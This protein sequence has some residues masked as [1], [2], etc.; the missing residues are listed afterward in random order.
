MNMSAQ[1]LRVTLPGSDRIPTLLLVDDEP[2]ILSAL[3]RLT[4]HEPWRIVT[5]NS[6]QEALDL[7]VTETPALIVSD[8]RMPGMSGADLLAQA[9]ECRPDALRL[10]LTGHA[11]V[12]STI[13][14]INDGAVYR[15]LTK[16]WDDVAMLTT[17]RDAMEMQRLRQETLRLEALTHAQNAELKALNT[18]LEARVT[19][20]T[21]ALQ[22]AVASL[23]QTHDKLKRSYLTTIK[24]FSN[25]IEL[26]EGKQAGHSRRVAD[27]AR[28]LAKQ[29]GC[30]DLETNDIFLAGLLHDIGKIG[31]PD[32]VTQKPFSSL[33]PE[34]RSIYVRHAAQAQ[35]ALMA[36]E[37]LNAVGSL[38][39]SHHER[40]D[41]LGYPDNLEG[42]TIPLGARILAVANDYEEL[43]DGS[44][45]P[46]RLEA[47]AAAETIYRAAGKRYDPQ[48]TDAL[49]TVLS[50]HKP[51]HDVIEQALRPHQLL[52]GMH[53]TQDLTSHDGV[54]LLARDHELDER[55]I[56]Q[57]L[58]FERS[59]G[60]P[61]TLHV[62]ARS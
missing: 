10:L 14:A 19:E 46:A 11:D 30:S 58:Q 41:G 45:Q 42:E 8:M 7:L 44:L 3:K 36:L 26:R 27:L 22:Q 32:T 52:P 2:N 28:R 33:T 4:R 51:V 40:F 23:E 61:L 48:V 16:P 47:D 1:A 6:G 59:D 53:L 12:Q 43:Q 31:L 9:R 25:L 57:I 54:L 29:L 20:R 55:I 49:H 24:V 37:H 15:Y 50:A 39:R 35:T 62:L 13:Q 34:E 60:H 18:E 5:A 17:L 56:A 38:I 21:S